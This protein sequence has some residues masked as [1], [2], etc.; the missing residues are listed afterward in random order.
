MFRLIWISTAAGIALEEEQFPLLPAVVANTTGRIHNGN[1][2]NNSNR[3]CTTANANPVSGT[4][5]ARGRS[6]NNSVTEQDAPLHIS[7]ATSTTTAA[8]G[9]TL[10]SGGNS[11]GVDGEVGGSGAAGSLSSPSRS[12]APAPAT[13]TAA[14]AVGLHAKVSRPPLG[15]LNM[16]NLSTSTFSPQNSV[17][18]QGKAFFDSNNQERNAASVRMTVLSVCS[19]VLISHVAVFLLSYYNDIELFFYYVGC[20]FRTYC[21]LRLPS[22][23]C[24]ALDQIIFLLITIT[25]CSVLLPQREP[26]QR[27]SY[28]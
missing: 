23:H 11:S 17:T 4:S 16:S 6:R 5:S 20:T 18:E 15:R 19:L 9:D 1:H 8:E 27:P 22:L 28:S 10:G 25:S 24:L 7:T 14:V 26:H 2:S 12:Y 3:A 21:R 13:A